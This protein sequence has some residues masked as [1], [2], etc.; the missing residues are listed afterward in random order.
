MDTAGSTLLPSHLEQ[1]SSSLDL[2]TCN[3]NNNNSNTSIDKN[4][5]AAMANEPNS[6][7]DDQFDR[8]SIDSTDLFDMDDLRCTD[9]APNGDVV[10]G[11]RDDNRISSY[12][13]NQVSDIVQVLDSAHDFDES[14]G[15]AHSIDSFVSAK[16]TLDDTN[17]G[18][19]AKD[20]GDRRDED[21]GGDGGDGDDGY[22]D[23]EEAHEDP[24]FD[25][26]DKA[27]E[28]VC[29]LCSRVFSPVCLSSECGSIH[30]HTFW[31]CN[32]TIRSFHRCT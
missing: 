6:D 31:L 18:H 2:D 32:V 15:N 30:V 4:T 25:F 3:N 14:N 11:G 24:I 26:L 1:T 13:V 27:N 17:D 20:G 28:V 12:E 19:G 23:D 22:D 5:L 7:T 8:D 10:D 16:A 9:N 21:D 29:A